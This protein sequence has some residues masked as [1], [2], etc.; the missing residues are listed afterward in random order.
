MGG[1][2]SGRAGRRSGDLTDRK[3]PITFA[4]PVGVERG[5]GLVGEDEVGVGP[6]TVP[7]GPVP[8]AP[9]RG[10][11]ERPLKTALRLAL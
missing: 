11:G 9:P 5:G 10:I 6:R 4:P 8:G 7:P 1:A 3:G 2:G